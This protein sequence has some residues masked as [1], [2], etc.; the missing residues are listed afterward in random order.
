MDQEITTNF[1]KC[2][3]SAMLTE[4]NG[5]L[6]GTALNYLQMNAHLGFDLK[7]LGSRGRTNEAGRG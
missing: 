1:N 3:N 5:R 4:K 7:Q 6:R 2:T